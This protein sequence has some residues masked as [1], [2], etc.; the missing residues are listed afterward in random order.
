M[1]FCAMK[2]NHLPL[3]ALMNDEQLAP[4]TRFLHNRHDEVRKCSS[5]YRSN[6]RSSA[7]LTIKSVPN[8][9][10]IYQ[11]KFKISVSRDQW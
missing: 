2:P 10:G 4:A 1:S 6:E 11:I 5:S 3:I 8:H 7:P 9:E